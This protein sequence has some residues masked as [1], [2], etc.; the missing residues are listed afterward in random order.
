MILPEM[1][2]WPFHWSLLF[3]SMSSTTLP[4]ISKYVNSSPSSVSRPK[5][6][7]KQIYG[8]VVDQTLLINKRYLRRKQK[9]R[10][11]LILMA[12]RFILWY[13]TRHSC[14]VA[15]AR[16]MKRERTNP[17]IWKKLYETC[18]YLGL[19]FNKEWKLKECNKVKKILLALA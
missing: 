17:I 7:V 1:V 16:L 6:R 10:T 8:L 11:K 5:D 3:E 19:T 4:Y 18:K 14:G 15:V 13:Q 2:V 9:C 12:N